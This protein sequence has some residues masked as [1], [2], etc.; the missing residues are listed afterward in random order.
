MQ[1]LVQVHVNHILQESMQK[2]GLQSV[3][4]AY[5]GRFPMPPHQL[6]L[7]VQME[8]IRILEVQLV[9]DVPRNEMNMY[10]VVRLEERDY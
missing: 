9:L 6:A 1:Y 4:N 2:E 10:T 7:L 3:K 8:C 5:H